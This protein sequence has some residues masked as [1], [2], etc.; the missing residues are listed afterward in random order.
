MALQSLLLCP[1]E[2]TARVLSRVLAEL[3]IGM[4]QCTEPFDAVKK[5]MRQRYDAVIVDWENEANATLVLKNARM[6]P[7]NKTSLAVAIVEGQ[8]SVRNA[9]RAGANFVLYKPISVEQAKTSLRAAR[10]LMQRGAEA[11]AKQGGESATGPTLVPPQDFSGK[12]SG[13]AQPARMAPVMPMPASSQPSGT[14]GMSAGDASWGN[15]GTAAAPARDHQANL[16][17]DL[18]NV[19]STAIDNLQPGSPPLNAAATVIEPAR[20]TA[21][22]KPF[23]GTKKGEEDSDFYHLDLDADPANETASKRSR[24]KPSDSQ[25]TAQSPRPVSASP[26]TSKPA[27]AG[28]SE[29]F[30]PKLEPAIKSG[31]S[32]DEVR[33]RVSAQAPRSS[34]SFTLGEQTEDTTAGIPKAILFGGAAVIVVAGAVFA[35]MHFHSAPKPHP[36]AEVTP[37]VTQPQAAQAEINPTVSSPAPATAAPALT[38]VA[39]A[40]SEPKSA[41]DTVAKPSAGK[42]AQI[43]ESTPGE[44]VGEEPE[45]QPEVQVHRLS[46]IQKQKSQAEMAEAAPPSMDAVSGN[47]SAAVGGLMQAPVSV[48]Q[49]VAPDRVRVSQG[50]SQGMLVEMVKPHYPEAARTMRLQGAVVLEALIG[51]DGAVKNLKVVTGHSMLA[52]AAQDAVRQWR[53]KPYLLNGQP[54]SVETQ[55]TVKFM[56]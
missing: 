1:D 44:S 50:V 15:A 17:D 56:P 21:Q 43:A 13:G 52:K 12:T 19:A 42:T 4:E 3:E 2:K 30:K 32:F 45:S 33:T 8:T 38:S 27:P 20:N 40:K 5:L 41:K 48:P 23:P 46:A 54:V 29:E 6:S 18:R 47:S 36:V 49:L 39:P 51:K 37:Q 7:S 14:P 26:A 35:F 11:A 55:I 53:Y 25:I 28:M 31:I 22:V 24:S 10:A 16:L 34:P 9:F